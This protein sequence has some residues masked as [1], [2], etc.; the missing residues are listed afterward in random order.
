MQERQAA[1]RYWPRVQPCS[2]RIQPPPQV[3]PIV[4]CSVGLAD[5]WVKNGRDPTRPRRH[6][7]GICL[8]GQGGNAIPRRASPS[9]LHARLPLASE[10][11]LGVKLAQLGFQ[12]GST[13]QRWRTTPATA[14]CACPHH[15]EERTPSQEAAL[16]CGRRG[17]AVL[18]PAHQN[19]Q[20]N[21]SPPAHGAR[22]APSRPAEGAA[23]Q[24]PRP[25]EDARWSGQ[26]PHLRRRI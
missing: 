1:E 9:E 21:R 23:S 17:T 8:V 22:F 26:D 12:R 19:C 24:G 11:R 14:R 13:R 2:V 3:A 7:M 20:S 10:T 6:W 18:R 4:A 25:A 15:L 16:C 5:A